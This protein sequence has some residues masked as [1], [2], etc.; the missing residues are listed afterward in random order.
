MNDITQRFRSALDHVRHS[1]S[2][3]SLIGG[4][5]RFA[6]NLSYTHLKAL[7]LAERNGTMRARVIYADTAFANKRGDQWPLASPDLGRIFR[8]LSPSLISEICIDQQLVAPLVETVVG[9]DTLA[10]P[11]YD[12]G[13]VRGGFLF[14]GAAPNASSIARAMLLVLSHAAF[15]R[16]LALSTM[17]EVDMQTPLSGRELQCIKALADGMTDQEIADSL[18]ISKRTVR[19]HIDGAKAKFGVRTRLEAIALALKERV[20]AVW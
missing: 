6:L 13:H 3:L 2:A 10:V 11:I 17:N 9:N 20:V 18:G 15:A 7:D 8:G 5:K 12:H 19:S 16:Y 4:V 14:S 1:Q